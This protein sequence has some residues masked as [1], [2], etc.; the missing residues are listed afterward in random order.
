MNR[1]HSIIARSL[2]QRIGADFELICSKPA[3]QVS[4]GEYMRAVSDSQQAQALA[5]YLAD[6]MQGVQR[7]AFCDACGIR[8]HANQSGAE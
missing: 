4:H 6:H 8:S 3:G 5:R 1:N 2:R 7:L